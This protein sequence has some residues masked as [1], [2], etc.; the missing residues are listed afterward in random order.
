[1]IKK[2]VYI[3][4]LFLI[5]VSL[6]AQIIQA[7]PV[8]AQNTATKNQVTTQPATTVALTTDAPTQKI[9]LFFNKDTL[10]PKTFT[11]FGLNP[12]NSVEFTIRKDQLVTQA[13][14][15]LQFT[16]SPS[17]IP[18]QSQLKIY[19]N[20]E[21]VGLIT[22][23]DEMLG[24]SNHLEIPI[25]PRFINDFNRLKLHFIGHYKAI[26]ENPAN[27]TLWMEI[28]KLSFLELMTQTLELK[29]ELTHFPEPFFDRL[30][31]KPLV[32]P[33]VFAAQPDLTQ[34]RAAAILASWFGAKSRWHGQSF[35][36][37]FN[38]LPG[39]NAIVLL[40]NTQ[41]PDFLK[42]YQTVNA[43]TVEMISHPDNPYIK[44]LVISGRDSN[45]LITAVKGIVTGNILFRGSSVTV[46][47][48]ETIAP[49]KPYDAPYWVRTDRPTSFEELQQFKEQLQTRG[50]NPSPISLPFNLPPDLFLNGS[51]GV[52]ISLKYRYTVPPPQG[53]SHLNVSLNNY[54]VQSFKLLSTSEQEPKLLGVVPLSA[55]NDTTKQFTIPV[56]DLGTNN[57]MVFDFAY[58]NSI[59]GGT[60]DGRC[61]SYTLTDNYAAIDGNSTIDFSNYYHYIALPNLR[62]FI[63]AGFP[64]SRLADLSETWILISKQP[65]AVE[66][67]TLL[68]TMGSIGSQTGF[69]VLAMSL[70]DD[71]AQL[72][73]KDVDTLIIGN[74][75]GELYDD[76]KINLLMKK[77]ESWINSPFRQAELPD[78]PVT[79]GNAAVNNKTVVSSNG[80]LA[81][82]IG[83]QSPYYKQRSIIGL[84]ADTPR[85]FEL[86]NET[87]SVKSLSGQVFGSVAV[88]KESGINSLQVGP[89][90]HVGYL[91]WYMHIWLALQQHPINMAL[92]SLVAALIVTYLLWQALRA[93]S[94]HR[95]KK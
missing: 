69:P 71:W 46:D 49:R 66:V 90:Y 16:P 89:I 68:N 48:V 79:P 32:L 70:T 11:I 17:L 76:S 10:T 25:D 84:L 41:R 83:L 64:F 50:F 80:V 60:I 34:Q 2:T 3:T 12:D 29:N 8:K 37:L 26:C 67:T 7:A 88:I 93:I 74:I 75:P 35:P 24:K 36:A 78:I 63:S 9:K 19:L 45:D 44:L 94:R 1:M 59:G 56:L 58:T 85:G 15:N 95:L 57:E 62:A 77:T 39:R 4:T 13:Q 65:L 40:T 14:L 61:E 23:I 5:A 20:E 47:Q 55:A 22:L 52:K 86:L 21:L 87:F 43:P 18:I 30:D 38:E 91:P 51:P 31:D 54:F 42:S 92:A 72:K 6:L 73:N 53:V 81:A 28:S 82:I 27:T 33:M